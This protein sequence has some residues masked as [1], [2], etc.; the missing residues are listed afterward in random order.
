MY[1][2]V[3]AILEM[4]PHHGATG[5]L[6]GFIPSYLR[7]QP[8][9]GGFGNG[10]RMDGPNGGRVCITPLA[11]PITQSSKGRKRAQSPNKNTY[12]HD[13]TDITK[14]RLKSTIGNS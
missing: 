11:V 2:V 6:P 13:S 3:Y 12:V 1:Q 9:S 5:V 7:S 14:E 10:Q 4:T 8:E